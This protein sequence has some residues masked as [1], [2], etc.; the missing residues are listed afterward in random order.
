MCGLERCT[1]VVWTDIA[2]GVISPD[3]AA[4]PFGGRCPHGSQDLCTKIQ[5]FFGIRLCSSDYYGC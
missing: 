3:L 5:A 1:A 4:I 2:T